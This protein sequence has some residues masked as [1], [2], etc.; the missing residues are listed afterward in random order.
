MA[1]IH[2]GKLNKAEEIHKALIHQNTSNHVVYP[3]LAA[4]YLK[5]N[6]WQEIIE[7]LEKAIAIHPNHP[8]AHNNLGNALRKQGD[9]STA[10]SSYSQAIRFKPNHVSAHFNLGNALKE[11]NEITAAISSYRKVLRLN[12]NIPRLIIIL[13]LP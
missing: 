11:Q 12:P 6:R 3:Q 4:I 13:V 1:F 5:T 10:I 7:L 9:L 2:Q 8:V